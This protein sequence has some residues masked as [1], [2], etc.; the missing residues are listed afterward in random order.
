M[1]LIN[2][3]LILL[4]A[5]T[6]TQS[7][8]SRITQFRLRN[9]LEVIVYVDSSAPVVS[10]NVFYRV[11]SYDEQPGSTG[12]SHMLEHM[13]F[14]HTDVYKPGDFDRIVDEAGGQNNGFTS[15]YY[16][17]YY[18]DLAKDRWELALRLE[19]ARMARCVFP[20]SEFATEH[21]VV[22]EERRLHDNN[23]N[24]VLWEQ[25][26]ATALLVNPQ[27]NS[28]IGWPEDVRNF[29]VTKVRDWYQRYYNPAN[30]VLVVAGD[31]RPEDVKAKVQK[32][33]GR[34]KGRPVTRND[35]Y[36]AEPKQTGERRITIRK[37]VTVPTLIIGY[38]APGMNDSLYYASEVAAS[39]LAS[40]R[41]SRLYKALVLDSG[42]ATSVW[43]YT[44]TE[45]DPGLFQLVVTPKSETL[46]PRLEHI[47]YSE[48]ARIQQEPV[49]ERELQRVQNQVL[50]NRIFERDDISGMAYL[51]A[52]SQIITGSWRGFLEF[53]Q[54][55]QKVTREQVQ[56]FCRQY[57][58]PERRTVG[59]L[60]PLEGEKQ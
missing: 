45:R 36:H 40:G 27:R 41:S 3:F 7:L 33:F 26:E 60:L 59:I 35:F 55:I 13:T 11:G 20:D 2:L 50:A 16:T 10:T 6:A 51:L 12:L 58:T 34:L 54:E 37:R 43:A 1:P 9:G 57:L 24:S 49:S 29:T 21:G 52:T 46:L 14:K 32:H 18:E 38:H 4:L 23:P 56:E 39:I 17:G 15:T 44:T 42:L 22:S 5:D 53:A 48:I 19:A 31:V 8:E 25:F 30:A 28:T 47:I